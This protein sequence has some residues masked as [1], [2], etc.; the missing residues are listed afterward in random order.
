MLLKG[1]RAR[2][3]DCAERKK[4]DLCSGKKTILSKFVGKINY[5]KIEPRRRLI[6][7]KHFHRNYCSTKK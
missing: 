4:D 3:V 7:E 1:K 5:R 2:I 6:W